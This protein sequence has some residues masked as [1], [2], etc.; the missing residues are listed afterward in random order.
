MA[1][2]KPPV[3]SLPKTQ[4]VRACIVPPPGFV[5]INPDYGQIEL[6]VAAQ[7]TRDER[8]LEV[9]RNG[10]DPHRT[11]AALIAGIPESDV[12]PAQR[13]KAKPPNFGFLFGMGPPRF[14]SYALADY[15]VV[16]TLEE[17]RK[18]RAGYLRAYPGIARWQA[19]IRATMPLEMRT[20]GGRI[21]SF[22]SRR[23]GYTERLNHPVQGTALD[24]FKAAMALLNPRLAALGA[25]TMLAVH[26]E[27]VVVAPE[28]RAEEVKACVV[29]SM[30]EGMSRFVTEVPVTVDAKICK[31]WAGES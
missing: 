7:V 20:L 21:R 1:C 24:G 17:A 29:A 22:P 14:V 30:V 5:L 3:L 23:E 28:S 25:W 18:F 8:L 27:L 26:D 2:S 6:R 4:D 13:T 11:T 15:G 16:F 9:F 31:N 19:R 10:G 12:T